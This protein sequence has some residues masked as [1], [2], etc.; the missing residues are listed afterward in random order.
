VDH[1]V[2]TFAVEAPTAGGWRQR[3]AE[4]AERGLPFL[5]AEDGGE[6]VGYAYAAPWNP[7]PGYRH[8]VEDTVY[9]AAGSAGLGLGRAL[10]GELVA[11]SGRAGARQMIGVVALDADPLDADPPDADPAGAASQGTASQG[12]ASLALHHALGF[13]EAGRLRAVG[14]KHGRWLDT[15]LMQRAL[16]PA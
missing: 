1:S 6:F 7:R 12:A 5:V 13:T 16:V 8:T 14:H 4:L 3:L 10:L 2:A 11:R 9:L 15:V